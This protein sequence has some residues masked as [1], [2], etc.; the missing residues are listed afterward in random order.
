MVGG[1][2]VSGRTEIQGRGGTWG[3]RTE[4]DS[5]NE[6]GSDDMGWGRA[7]GGWETVVWYGVVRQC[8]VNATVQQMG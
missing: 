6:N 7:D 8:L 4:F 5:E 2:V 3:R 1:V